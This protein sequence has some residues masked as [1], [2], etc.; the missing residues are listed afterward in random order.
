M[1]VYGAQVCTGQVVSVQES[2]ANA[3]TFFFST[4][5][6][7][8]FIPT[9]WPAHSTAGVYSAVS[10]NYAILV[11]NVN[12]GY[13]YL[14]NGD[15]LHQLNPR[16]AFGLSH[17]HHYLYLITIDGRQPGYSDGAYD[18]E[19]AA[20]LQ[21]FGAWEGADMD[22]GG[23]TTVV[24][25]DSTLA[26]VML[27]HASAVADSGNQRLVGSHIGF[28]AKP[29]AGFINDLLANPDNN[30]ATI[31]WTTTNAAT[32]Q[33]QYGPTLAF[34]FSTPLISTLTTNHA[35]LLT[36]LTPSSG[37]YFKV[38][39]TADANTYAS[40][41]LFFVT[42]NYVVTSLAFDVTNVWSWSS[43]NLTGVNWTAKNYDSSTW[44][45]GPGCLWFDS[46]GPG[47]ALPLDRTEM[48]PPGNP[49]NPPYPFYTY[50]FRTHFTL[51]GSPV[52]GSLTL[53]NFV[54]DGAVFYLNGAEAFRLRLPAS[55]TVIGNS[56]L[57]TGFPGGGDATNADVFN[58]TGNV[59]TNAVVGDNVLAVEVHN[60]NTKSAD[61][62]FG[63]A[64]Y[65]SV[66]YT[67]R[68]TLNVSNPVP[69]M[70]TLSWTRGGFTLQQAP[71]PSG[72][73]T[74][75]SGPVVSSPYST[76]N[77]GTAVFYRLSK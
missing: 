53:S 14:G 17:D 26:P 69:G 62:T 20:W 29:V 65:Y 38:I 23:S 76:G 70:T 73:W 77:S 1:H 66:P 61:I 27:N 9:N 58:L 7:G 49:S 67:L 46:R 6:Q 50:Y 48:G 12:L 71:T 24:Q 13:A 35:A 4:N 19:T 56:T 74:D 43:N 5:N 21:M 30:A 25:Q 31:T 52:G 60:Y 55:P 15:Q 54:D 44:P 28:Y 37:Y 34:G 41:N 18:W 3:A 8:T 40:S 16:T 39:S 45:S 10:G 63:S 68:P 51:P 75:V 47:F 57:A 59:L 42:T 33:V 2:S 11:N 32:T 36:N 64:L 72:P 22:G